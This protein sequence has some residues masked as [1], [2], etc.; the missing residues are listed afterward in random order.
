M[1]LW[2]ASLFAVALTLPF[3]GAAHANDKN[4]G[5]SVTSARQVQNASGKQNG[6]KAAS[7]GGFNFG[8]SGGGSH[9]S[10]STR[11]YSRGGG[12]SS[13]YHSTPTHTTKSYN[14]SSHSS[15]S[16]SHG[17]SRHTSSG[18]AREF[19]ATGDH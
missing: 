6:R 15:S 10:R 14:T 13:S 4:K 7:F 12:R 2:Q 19:Q 1:K 5:N 3:T 16:S 17:S 9:S 11:S 8:G 18:N